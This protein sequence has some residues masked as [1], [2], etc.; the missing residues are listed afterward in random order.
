M[1]AFLQIS[2]ININLSVLFNTEYT[3]SKVSSESHFRPTT[4]NAI[5]RKTASCTYRVSFIN[6]Y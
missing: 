2:C 6:P 4:K 1:S 3:I 5:S